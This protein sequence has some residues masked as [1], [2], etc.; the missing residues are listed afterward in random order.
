MGRI[1]EKF[2]VLKE[3]GE[4]ALVIYLTAGYPS[5]NATREFIFALE[6]TGVDIIELG[7]PFSDPTADG[8]IIQAA[9]Q[10][11]LKEGTTL[12]AVLDLVS[13]VR[14]TSEIPIVLFGYYNPIFAYGNE[15]FAERSFAAGLDGVLVVDLP[16]EEAQELRCFTDSKGIDYISL[17][18]PP[19]GE[20]R[21]RK[22]TKASTGFLYF[23]SV[24]GVTGTLKPVF[25]DIRRGVDQIRKVSSL[26]V[27]VGFG[28]SNPAQAAEIASLGDGIV[29]GSAFIKEISEG[30]GKNDLA[31]R[32]ST[33]ANNLK[34]SMVAGFKPLAFPEVR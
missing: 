11:A 15:R 21:I 6:R 12:E 13:E 14:R 28:I 29:V 25:E 3:K 7:V 31:K 2:K 27:V 34:N 9:S 26:P 8:P 1:E 18:A 10:K 4:K 33:F 19:T 30:H 5:L 17:V 32:I 22:I 24:T 23:V 16:F 20:R